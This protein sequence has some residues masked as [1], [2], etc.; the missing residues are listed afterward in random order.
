MVNKLTNIV[1]G[2]VLVGGLTMPIESK[3]RYHDKEYTIEKI[4]ENRR[5]NRSIVKCNFLYDVF[6]AGSIKQKIKTNRM[7]IQLKCPQVYRQ[8]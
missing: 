7:M 4:E 8:T 6:K 5:D 1:A 2:A 3:A